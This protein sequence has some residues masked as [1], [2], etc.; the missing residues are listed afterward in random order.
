MAL[1]ATQVGRREDLVHARLGYDAGNWS[2][3]LWGRNLTDEDNL[4]SLLPVSTS[5]AQ[6]Y[7]GRPR[8][9]SVEFSLAY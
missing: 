6:A 2:V 1:L 9:L 7:Y 4:Y 5:W 3:A 8:W